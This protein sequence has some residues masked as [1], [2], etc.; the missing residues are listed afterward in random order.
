[1]KKVCCLICFML[2]LLSMTL[3]VGA[4][5][6]A[7]IED[8][9]TIPEDVLACLDADTIDTVFCVY[10]FGDEFARCTYEGFVRYGDIDSILAN[11]GP[12]LQRCYFVK[13]KDGETTVYTY[14][15]KSLSPKYMGL[16]SWFNFHG[17]K[18]E[19]II[20]TIDAGIVVENIYYLWYYNWT[21]I[22]YK[23]NLGDY[24]YVSGGYLMGR[25]PFVAL[26]EELYELSYKY[27]NWRDMDN[28]PYHVKLSQLGAD[29]S[30]YDITSPDFDP[31][32]PLHV[33]HNYK[34]GKFIAIGS[35][36]L[37]MALV[38]CRIL[39][40][41]RRKTRGNQDIPVNRF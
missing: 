41:G 22:Y 24:V 12:E 27:R 30:P 9:L 1:M 14:D 36:A 37:L 40:R 38:V 25:E 7:K 17:E 33:E 8:S 6:N 15:G 19:S 35:V 18:A 4:K 29:L 28:R 2:L 16:G 26:Q 11:T 13:D 5:E 3:P 31:Q 10:L 21:A 39:I 23:T 34:P 20:Q 32:A